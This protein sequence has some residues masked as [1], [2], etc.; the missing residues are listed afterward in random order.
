MLKNKKGNLIINMSTYAMLQI[1]NMLVGLLLPRLF[2]SVYG[3]EINGVISTVN[4]FVSYFSY[5][6]A[7][8]GLTLIHSLFKPLAEKDNNSINNVISFSKKQYRKISV[9][10]FILVLLLSIVFPLIRRTAAMTTFEF[11]SLVFVIG[12]YGTIDFFAMAKYRV[13]LTADRKEYVISAAMILAQILRFVLVWIFLQFKISVVI[14][15]IVPILTLLVR[16]VLLKLYI[17]K[18][19]PNVDYSVQYTKSIE[20]SDKRWDA[21]LLQISINT[22]TSL[23]AILIST[24]LGFKEANVYAVYSMIASAIIS[25]VSA[26]SS[27]VAP[28][29]GQNISMGIDIRSTYRVYDYIVSIV[30]TVVFSVMAVMTIPFVKLYTSV[31][32]DI[33]YVNPIFAI[34][35]SVWAALHSYRIP[36]TAVINASGLYK[37]NRLNNILNLLIQVVVGIILVISFGIAGILVAMIF[38]A[39]QRNISFDRVINRNLFHSTNA[40]AIFKQMLIGL[41]IIVSYVILSPIINKFNYTFTIWVFISILVAVLESIIALLV[42]GITDMKMCKK[43]FY[44]ILN[45]IRNFKSKIM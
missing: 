11:V 33:N 7:G 21:L 22:S 45:V 14:V 38:A 18:N 8:I 43:L 16:T 28:K 20:V 42:F 3:S 4:S 35:M 36:M 15:K 37:E 12:L 27:G 44:E 32:N 17:Q 41:T 24:A 25:V 29:L 13:L 23:P 6:E 34:L 5:L 1:V 9:I 31:V 39:I 40:N 26:L 2:L 10:Y 19:Y 30:I